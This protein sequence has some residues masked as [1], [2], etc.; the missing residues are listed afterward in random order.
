[1]SGSR[2]GYLHGNRLRYRNGRK[3][4]NQFGRMYGYRFST[5]KS[6]MNTTN[7]KVMINKDFFQ[8]VSEMII[9]AV[10]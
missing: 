4:G 9:T 1:M 3:Y 5:T 2:F 7:I 10:P 8:Q 6:T